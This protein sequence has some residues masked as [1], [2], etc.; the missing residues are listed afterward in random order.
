MLC[1]FA[2]YENISTARQLYPKR[3]SLMGYRC[4]W[5]DIFP[6]STKQHRMTG[7][8]TCVKCV[9]QVYELHVAH[10]VV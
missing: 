8:I 6:Y 2:E 9:L 7:S 1:F 3:Q 10:L 5:V 4:L